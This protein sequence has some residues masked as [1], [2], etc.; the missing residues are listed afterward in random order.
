M[1]A[2]LLVKRWLP[3]ILWTTH[4]LVVREAVEGVGREIVVFDIY[5]PM[6]PSP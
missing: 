3:D 4:F 1:L 2:F 5:M 6:R